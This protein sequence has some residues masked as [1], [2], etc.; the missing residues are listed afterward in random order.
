MAAVLR[1]WFPHLP[2]N[3]KKPSCAA[4]AANWNKPAWPEEARRSRSSKSSAARR[5]SAATILVPVDRGRSTRSA[6]GRSPERDRPLDNNGGQKL[7]FFRV[8]GPLTA[9]ALSSVRVL[10]ERH[11]HQRTV[12]VNRGTVCTDSFSC[13][14]NC[15][16]KVRKAQSNRRGQSVRF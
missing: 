16:L 2:T 7:R 9:I 14:L 10:T 6:T 15:L 8:N 3:S 1:E 12:R 13:C 4:S 5:R 11:P